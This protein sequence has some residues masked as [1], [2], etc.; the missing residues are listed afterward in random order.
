MTTIPIDLKPRPATENPF[1]VNPSNKT[2]WAAIEAASNLLDQ[3]NAPQA[4]QQGEPFHNRHIHYQEVL[5]FNIPQGL[6]KDLA[7]ADTYRSQ[8]AR[9]GNH[10]M[11]QRQFEAALGF[12]I[13]PRLAQRL[14]N[15]Q[16]HEGRRYS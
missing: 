14:T 5:G 15:R 16:A 11:E 8:T 13:S 3:S 4:T 9:A 7:F 10:P 6:A 2:M 12:P 1:Q